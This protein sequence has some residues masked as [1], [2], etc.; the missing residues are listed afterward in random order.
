VS[1]EL[2]A[3]DLK[4]ARAKRHLAKLKESIDAALDPQGYS[5]SVEIDPKTGHHVYRVR[6]VPAVDPEWPLQVGEILYQLRSALDHL[7]WQLVELDGTVPNEQT[8]FPIR[9]SP[10]DKNGNTR[11][12]RDLMPQI[13]DPKIW[14]L[15]NECQPYH[16]L[17]GV[18]RTPFDAHSDPLWH[19]KVLNNVD[20]HR[21]LLVVVYGLDMDSMWWG[22]RP[23]D[24]A[25]IHK[26]NAAA[27]EENTP[28]VWF[29]FHGANPPPDFD[30][31]PAIQVALRDPVAPA[32]HYHPLVGIIDNLVRSVEWEVVNMRFR[33]LFP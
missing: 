26:I 13:K 28:V 21:L 15:L 9:D 2:A 12:L 16:A 8:Q 10:L 24:V 17:D 7:A 29:D 3:V 5:F 23:G 33:S 22:L 1:A 14:G 6:N 4:I 20:K 19:I 11:P 32:L 30:P 27:L 31:H 25:P 18:T